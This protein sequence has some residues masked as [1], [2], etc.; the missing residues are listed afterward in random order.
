MYIAEKSEKRYQSQKGLR[1]NDWLYEDVSYDGC[2][3]CYCIANAIVRYSI[4]LEKI[5]S[6]MIIS[7]ETHDNLLEFKNMFSELKKIYADIG[8]QYKRLCMD[9]INQ[10]DKADQFVYEPSSSSNMT[11][12]FSENKEKSILRLISTTPLGG[13]DL[14]T[15]LLKKTVGGVAKG[16]AEIGGFLEEGQK[17]TS[18]YIATLANFKL[19]SR[20]ELSKIFERVRK[21][22]DDYEYKF[23][24]LYEEMMGAKNVLEQ[25]NRIISGKVEFN[26]NSLGEIKSMLATLNDLVSK[27]EVEL[28]IYCET[29]IT[30]EDIQSFTSDFNNQHI[31]ISFEV[32]LSNFVY[33]IGGVDVVLMS[34]FQGK[35]ITD[36]I[37]AA[38]ASGVT[39][40]SGVENAYEYLLLK[41]E[42]GDIISDVADSELDSERLEAYEEAKKIVGYFKDSENFVSD[43]EQYKTVYK[44]IYGTLS[45]LSDGLGIGLDI[46]EIMVKMLGDYLANEKIIKSLAN[47]AR[48]GSMLKIVVDQLVFEYQ[49]QFMTGVTDFYELAVAESVKWAIGERTKEVLAL[50]GQEA[51]GLYSL[52][53]FGIKITG[54]LS[55]VTEISKSKLQFCSLYSSLSD[56]EKA[57][58]KNFNIVS[59]G[60]I[61]EEAVLDLKNSFEVLKKTYL[62]LYQLMAD[63]E[64]AAG[65]F[66]KK[67]YYEYI[68]G[69]IEKCSISAHIQDIKYS[70]YEEFL[71]GKY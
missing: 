27:T 2:T 47:N 4:G 15:C 28:D 42:L 6:E 52:A 46:T 43:Y 13:M 37:V 36:T 10:I 20:D 5:A 9:F 38:K 32:E 24:L 40:P 35:E 69:K 57:Y 18:I 70:T 50:A 33:N 65:N 60:D 53:Q 23:G 55:G 12:D 49:N 8:E 68:Y 59:N 63:S 25:A 34:I 56:I 1:V 11:R 30:I 45:K 61:S 26:G 39:I 54:Q 66:D 7:G 21:V 31:F 29:D 64:D 71:L 16:I 41:K 44:A 17:N 58:R 19:C 48:D 22:D 51:G 14:I 67:A 3:A 62:R